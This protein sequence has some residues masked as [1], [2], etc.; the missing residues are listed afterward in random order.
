[1]MAASLEG[2]EKEDE[3]PKVYRLW[4]GYKCWNLI[5]Q[6]KRETLVNERGVELVEYLLK[7]PPDEA[8]HASELEDRVDGS[9]LMDGAGGIERG[10]GE[11]GN[12]AEVGGVIQEGAGKKLMGGR[13]DLLRR[14]LAKQKSIR[15]DDNLPAEE[16]ESAEETILKLL[17]AYQRGGKM[18]GGAEQAVDRVRKAI[19]GLIKD[20][21]M[22]EVTR[23]KPN[24]VLGAFGEHLQR[25]LWVP[26]MGA[27][28]R[29]GASGRPGCFTYE[30]PAGVVWED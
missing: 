16:R 22:P 21:M 14:E 30:R 25:Y 26:S 19:K 17:K 18:A 24:A 3:G 6:G 7:H 27:R 13:G 4:K 10:D 28:G 20:L 29:A 12:V 1:M 2:R 11:G 5:F 15:D 8:I 9:P 23:G